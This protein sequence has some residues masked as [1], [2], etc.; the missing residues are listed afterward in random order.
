MNKEEIKEVLNFI[1]NKIE[2]KNSLLFDKWNILKNY[3]TNL[4]QENKQ[5]K[6][7][8]TK[9]IEVIKRSGGYKGICT[10]SETDTFSSLLEILR[11]KE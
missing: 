5:L 3:I 7:Y 4:Q 1:E 9:A 6:E 8:K 2:P 10:M 11:G